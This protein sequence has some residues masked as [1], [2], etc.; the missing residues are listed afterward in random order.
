MTTPTRRVTVKCPDC[1]RVYSDMPHP[2]VDAR[3]DPGLDDYVSDEGSTA[4][5]PECG[6]HVDFDYLVVG[7]NGVWQLDPASIPSTR[8]DSQT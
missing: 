8:P 5:C 2:S 7:E 1:D 3:R 4:T 6:F